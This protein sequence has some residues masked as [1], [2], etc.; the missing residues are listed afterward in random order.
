MNDVETS[1]IVLGNGNAKKLKK[2]KAIIRTLGEETCEIP[3]INH[4]FIIKNIKES[5]VE[6]KTYIDIE[7]IE[8]KGLKITNVN[9]EGIINM[10]VLKN[11]F[12]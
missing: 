5:L 10:E 6:N 9:K 1:I 3:F 8:E 11:V 4:E 2:R 12:K 7:P